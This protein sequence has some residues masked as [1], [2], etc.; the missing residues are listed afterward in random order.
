MKEVSLVSALVAAEAA[1][2]SSLV[3]AQVAP[4]LVKRSRLELARREA[5]RQLFKRREEA[6]R[7]IRDRRRRR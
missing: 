3:A 7:R 4:L 2:W 6:A 1:E 5:R